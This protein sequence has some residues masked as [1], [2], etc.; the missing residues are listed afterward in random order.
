MTASEI[1]QGE[2]DTLEYKLDI[3]DDKDKFVKTAIAFANSRGGKLVFCVKNDSWNIVGLL[4]EGLFLKMD[5]IT[6]SIYDSTEPK[7]VPD[8]QIQEIDGKTIIV[9]T[10]QKGMEKPY[11]LKSEGILQ[12]TYIRIGATTC[13]AEHDAVREL[14]LEGTNRSFD[15][16]KAEGTVTEVEAETFCKKLYEKALDKSATDSMK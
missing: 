1:R 8:C 3:T 12:G 9:V 6:R 10:I 11:Y 7:I 4:P 15:Q 2:S 5:D 13:K 14:I 16:L